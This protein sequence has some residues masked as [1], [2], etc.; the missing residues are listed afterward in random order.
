M[1]DDRLK[2]RLREGIAVKETTKS[3]VR[4]LRDPFWNE[5]FTGNGID[6][7]SGDDPFHNEWFPNV[8][9][10]RPFDKRDGD[11]QYLSRYIKVES[12]DFL[13]ASNCLEHLEA[14][15]EAVLGWLRVVKPGGYVVFTVPDE[16]LYE[17]GVFPSRWNSDHRVTFTLFKEKS[18]SRRSI[19]LAK[20]LSMIPSCRVRRIELADTGYDRS[21]R[22]IDQTLGKAEAFWEVVIGKLPVT[23]RK[24]TFKH[25]GARGDLIYGLAAILEMGGGTLY[26][27][28]GEGTVFGMPV[29][30]EEMSGMLE[31][32]GSL[33]YVEAKEWNGE[34]VECDMDGFRKLNI[35]Y[36]FLSD[37]QEM[38]F[39]VAHDPV[40]PWIDPAKVEPVHEADIVV[41][42][43]ERYHA[44]FDWGELR[45]W[46]ARCVFVGTKGEH[47]DFTSRTGLNVRRV[48][49]PS[50][51]SL[52]GVI[53]G[54]KLFVGNQ[55]MAWALAEAMKV[56][57]VLEVYGMAP[58]C[59]PRGTDGHL[60]LTQALIRR[61]VDGIGDADESGASRNPWLCRPFCRVRI[62]KERLS[63]GLV[64]PAVAPVAEFSSLLD[65]ARVVGCEISV[66]EGGSSFEEM[67]NRGAAAVR[68][69]AICVIDPRV[70]MELADVE[71]V[72]QQLADGKTGLVGSCMVVGAR[73]YVS[74]PCFAVSRKAYERLGLFNPVMMPGVLNMLELNLR[75]VR[76]S[77]GCKSASLGKWQ[78]WSRE[79]HPEWNDR[80]K[81]YIAKVY[82]VKL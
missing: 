64:V 68:G 57:R 80:N 61:Y 41:A 49:T 30:D 5:V 39:G 54:G 16:D 13:Y 24:R 12:V 43:S 42:R 55:S 46:T 47:D 14:P 33:G 25:S 32:L 4:R 79:E 52:A 21:L 45:P 53:R 82:G 2:G 81:A 9:S 60:R 10:V 77:C 15:L 22:N 69:Q 70:K 34:A 74:G 65:K 56:P 28:R 18:W 59:D 67:A 23:R 7:G 76:G 40:R 8:R 66:I 71:M 44:P 1:V 20:M 35:D 29:C 63:F 17:Q 62:Q 72:V 36:G 19:S 6:V 26:I 38:L 11:A 37:A 48:V 31:F 75:Y 50:W 3:L 78:G 73:P 51:K 58:N 27:N